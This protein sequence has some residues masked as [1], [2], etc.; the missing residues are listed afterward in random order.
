MVS[1]L[2]MYS[3]FGLANW[4]CSAKWDKLIGKWPMANCY[5]NLCVYIYVCVYI[6]IYVYI[7]IYIYVYMYICIYVYMYIYI[8]IYIYMYM[9]ICIYRIMQIVHSGNFRGCMIFFVIRM[10]TFAIVQ[11][12]KTPY[13]EKEKNCWKTFTIE[14]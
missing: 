1:P 2:E 7:Y 11:Q 10:K 14:G 12:F 5:F 3:K 9:Y 8:Y 4:I 6:C 13:N